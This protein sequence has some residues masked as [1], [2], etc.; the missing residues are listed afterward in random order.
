MNACGNVRRLPRRGLLL[1]FALS[2]SVL[3]TLPAQG[4][5]PA[6]TRELD[7]LRYVLGSE[8]VV[9]D[10][11]GGGPELRAH[12][13]MKVRGQ[14]CGELYVSS[15][16]V[17]RG[18]SLEQVLQA[19]IEKTRDKLPDYQPLGTKR[20]KAGDF[21]AVV[22]DFGY[23]V[24]VP[25]R[26]RVYVLLAGGSSYS[27][28]FN[29]T[30]SYFG[31]V[32]GTFAKVMASVKRRER[33]AVPVADAGPTTVEE[34]GLLIDLPAGWRPSGDAAGAKYR[35]YGPQGETLASFFPMTS[36]API[37]A[38]FGPIDAQIDGFVQKQQ[39]D[40][41]RQFEHATFAPVRRLDVGG[42]SVRCLDCDCEQA[43]VQGF[44]R[45]F[46][47][48]VKDKPDEGAV[49]Y[50]WTIRQFGFFTTRDEQLDAR[51]AQF[52][53]IIKTVRTKGA[54][55]A[56]APGTTPAATGDL[57]TLEPEAEPAGLFRDAAGRFELPLPE[58]ARQES[59]EQALAVYTVA[60]TPARIELHCLPS[61]AE[62]ATKAL[63]IAEGK[64]AN[65]KEMTWQ[66]G[67]KEAVV[68]L[69][70]HKDAAGAALAT[71]VARYPEAALVVAV[72][73]PAKGYA[74]A[75]AWITPFLKGLRYRG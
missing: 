14:P 40:L 21:D 37:L 48:P 54:A 31:A 5:P 44:F 70:T 22:H 64:K 10:L 11:R 49:Q 73:L 42:I 51:K 32:E 7:D 55:A 18:Q 69:Y 60:A 63:A 25:F 20:T 30:G 4:A 47:L 61:A 56:T 33:P 17:A 9:E 41:G 16:S 19:G 74:E 57:P 58:S 45:W 71:L 72:E 13:A 65:G 53:S 29:T 52:D 43:G 68:R 1:L 27:F 36:N 62:A 75:Q 67:G 3:A 28:F 59:R 23:T 24:G 38:A 46:F 34:H 66:V 8:W 6:G 50:G 15:E 2:C 39:D 26:G 35:C 12:Y